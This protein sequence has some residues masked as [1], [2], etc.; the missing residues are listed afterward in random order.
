[1]S[2]ETRPAP[3]PAALGD[4]LEDGALALR[5]RLA[6]GALGAETLIDRCLAR[7]VA[8]EP[9]VRAW[10]SVDP[11]RARAEARRADVDRAAGAAPGPLHGLP[12]GLKDIVD[13]A[14]TPTENGCRLDAGRI[15]DRDAW[16]VARLRAAGAVIL[17]KTVTTELA[18]LHPGPT[19][20]PHDP[21]HTPGGSSSGSAAAV[22]DGHVPL[23]VGTQ[24]GG[25][26]I[27]PASFCGVVGFK[28]S[29]GAIPRTGVLVQSP[30]LDTIGTFAADPAG[31]AL[32]AEV[33]F[34]HDPGDRA[35]ADRPRPGLVAAVET[36]PQRPPVLGLVQ[37]PGWDE[38]DPDMRGA[39]TDLARSLGARTV[40]L[41]PEA[42]DAALHRQTINFAEMARHFARYMEAG[43]DRLGAETLAAIEAGRAIPEADYCAAL[44]ARA[45]L[46]AA[47]APTF[48]ACDALL[49]PAAPGPAPEGLGSTG[50]SIFNGIWT[51]CGAPAITLP[52]LSASSGLPM[53]AQLVAGPGDDAG[54]LSA[55]GWLWRRAAERGGAA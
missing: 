49:C 54:L 11:D 50:D 22:A 1:M 12:V 39:L 26:V 19:R 16:I 13:T 52:L 24:T 31:A 6:S 9:E 47:L 46:I 2:P 28:P 32:L 41:P 55:A 42:A 20:N 21:R 14:R 35:T 51:L 36:A 53:G 37:P 44:A 38:A 15:P 8:R 4:P 34:G 29:F 3:R 5:D 45:A 27:R 30:S 43:R 40:A 17:G 18:Y 48:S 33:L 23:A 25:S 7:I 10:A